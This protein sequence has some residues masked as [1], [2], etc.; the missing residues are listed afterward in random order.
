VTDTVAGTEGVTTTESF[1]PVDP[2]AGPVNP[3]GPV[4]P[5]PLPVPLVGAELERVDKPLLLPESVEL[6]P[7]KYARE[8]RQSRSV[9]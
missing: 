1:V 4:L 8:N 7:D 9:R 6:Q 2:P 3:P 5:P